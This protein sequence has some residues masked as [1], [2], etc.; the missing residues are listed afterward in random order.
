[1]KPISNW[2]KLFY[3]VFAS[4]VIFFALL[5]TWTFTYSNY[6]VN[7]I[8]E[9]L[10]KEDFERL[11]KNYEHYIKEP[12][13]IEETESFVIRSYHVVGLYKGDEQE[14]KR[15]SAYAFIL[16]DIDETLVNINHK[17]KHFKLV[18]TCDDDVKE[19]VVFLDHY[20]AYGYLSF[21][22]HTHSIEGSCKDF[23]D[24]ALYDHQDEL[25]YSKRKFA[26]PLS[27]E[28]IREQGERGYTLLQ[29][30]RGLFPLRV[31]IPLVIVFIIYLVIFRVVWKL[32]KRYWYDK[33]KRTQEKI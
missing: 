26:Y 29:T 33:Q 25:V 14:V 3:I 19:F 31:T 20:H 32:L 1:M 18:I 8:E 22:L 7:Y 24:I 27:M 21:E 30:L 17:E 13:F 6:Y 23:F 12:V 10:E 2:L 5:L 4:L 9:V 11:L 15:N 28:E 16:T